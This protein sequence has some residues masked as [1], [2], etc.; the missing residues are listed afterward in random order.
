MSVCG[1]VA[2]AVN[3]GEPVGARNSGERRVWAGARAARVRGDGHGFAL[4]TDSRLTV[5]ASRCR[6]PTKKQVEISFGC[7]VNLR[8]KRNQLVHEYFLQAAFRSRRK[9]WESRGELCLNSLNS[10]IASI[11]ELSLNQAVC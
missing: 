6:I 11:D 1:R 7:N 8:K 3:A 5:V 9:N 10:L 2:C 4:A